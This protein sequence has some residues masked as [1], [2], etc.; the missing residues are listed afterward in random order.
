MAESAASRLLSG[1]SCQNA[2]AGLDG[3][4]RQIN[5][6]LAAAVLLKFKFERD[7]HI[8]TGGVAGSGST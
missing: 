5:A 3:C 1:V 2:E 4:A 7:S 8:E 6:R